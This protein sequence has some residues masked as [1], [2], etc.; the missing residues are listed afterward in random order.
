VV[1]HAF[2]SSSGGIDRH[3]SDFMVCLVY[4]ASSKIARAIERNTVS[5]TNEQP[6]TFGPMSEKSLFISQQKML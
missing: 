3:I 1:A 4:E 5:K 6:K 2:S